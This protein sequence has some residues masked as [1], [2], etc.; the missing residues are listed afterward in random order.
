MLVRRS[1]SSLAGLAFALVSLA[2]CASEASSA[3]APTAVG[4]TSD[5][6]P[7]VDPASQKPAL[8]H[9]SVSTKYPAFA[10]SM[11]RLVH[12]GGAVLKAPHIITIVYDGDPNAAAYEKLADEIGASAYWSQVV[13]EYGV[14]AASSAATSHVRMG[15][16]PALTF[17]PNTAPEEAVQAYVLQALEDTAT[18]HWPE[19][20]EDVI[21]TLF[22][23]GDLAQSMCADGMGGFHA[24]VDV[25]GKT[26]AYALVLACDGDPKMS[27][28]DGATVSA[29]H[30]W[31]EA[32]TDPYPEAKPAWEGLGDDDLGWELMVQGQDENGDLCEFDEDSYGSYGA[33][34]FAS[35]VQRQWSNASAAAGHAPC[36]PAPQN[37]YFN[38]ALLD[39]KS[40]AAKITRQEFPWS[41]ATRG[42]AAAVGQSVDVALGFV[43]D[44]ATAPF[45]ITA[46]ELD[47]FDDSGAFE[48]PPEKRTLTLSLDKTT[49]QNGEK[50]YLHVQVDK[51]SASGNVHLVLV[52][53]TLGQERHT[54]PIVVVDGP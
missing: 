18:S 33:P 22:F 44:A 30:E 36:V 1:F 32:A 21:Y 28:L 25:K 13:S 3:P 45:T 26:I 37:P 6:P 54:M 23:H 34:A 14:G 10:P 19:P 40:V 24:S 8:D 39:A 4:P 53:A 38:V 12:Q 2:G 20:K 5:A 17:G 46:T 49:G 50:A 27:V 7:A 9:G 41:K 43:S 48:L 31:A 11:P 42:Y 15:A 52:D 51:P 16:Q 35:M 29:S 47:P